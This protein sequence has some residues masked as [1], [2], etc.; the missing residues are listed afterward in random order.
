LTALKSLVQNEPGYPFYLHD[1]SI[2][3]K[4]SANT[5]K[6]VTLAM[7][8]KG[9]KLTVNPKGP[10]YEIG[11]YLPLKGK[12][13]PLYALKVMFTYFLQLDDTLYLPD[14]LHVLAAADLFGGKRSK[15]LVHAAKYRTFK[16]Q[17][18]DKLDHAVLVD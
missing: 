2:A 13:Y 10:F 9:V 11:G 12:D 15:L 1:E 17:F 8:G 5:L 4:V 6:P 14:N 16:Q 7:P 3:E 18:L